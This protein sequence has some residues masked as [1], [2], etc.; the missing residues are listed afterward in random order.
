MTVQVDPDTDEILPRQ[1]AQDYLR[2]RYGIRTNLAQLA[3][4]R[5]GPR[6]LKRGDGRTEYLRSWLDQY[7]GTFVREIAHA[8]DRGRPLSATELEALART[9]RS[10]AEEASRRDTSEEGG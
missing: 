8:H 4:R 2:R 6:M 10:T 1:E 9:K 5:G 3:C 7:A